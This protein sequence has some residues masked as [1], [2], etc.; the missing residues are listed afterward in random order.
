M[1]LT[2]KRIIIV[3]V[4]VTVTAY[5]TVAAFALLLAFFRLGFYVR[6]DAASTSPLAPEARRSPRASP[7]IGQSPTA[8]TAPTAP[9]PPAPPVGHETP[10]NRDAA[11]PA[12]TPVLIKPGELMIPVAG[13]GPEQLRDT[14][15]ESRSEGRTHNALDIMASCD[16]PVVA[17]LAGKIIKL[18]RSERG[19]VTIY[20]MSADDRTVYYYAHLARYADG[21]AEGRL[22]Q[23]GEVIGYVGDTGN[24]VPGACHLHFAIWTVADPK[25]YWH[26]ENINPYPLLRP[27]P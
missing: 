21:L 27:S 7:V 23:Q 8:P 19:G 11:R 10:E 13:I 6:H 5:A 16:T 15:N 2:T 4:F 1:S 20:Q 3:A 9:L 25:R 18:F 12:E 26:G 22:A 17:A 24:V 14:Y